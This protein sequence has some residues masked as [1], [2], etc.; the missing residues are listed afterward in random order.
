MSKKLLLPVYAMT[1][2]A[3]TALAN[4]PYIHEVMEYR[5]A[6]GQFINVLPA[7][8][9]GETPAE[10]ATRV[11]AGKQPGGMICL[12]AFGGYTVFRF[13]HPVANVQGDYDFK[14]SGNAPPTGSSEPGI[15]SVSIDVNQNGLPDD[16]WYE[17]AGSNYALETTLHD[18]SVTYRRPGPDDSG[19]HYI[20]WTDNIG[21]EGW[22]ASNAFH[23]QPYWLA[24]DNDS[25]TL[26]FAGTRLAPNKV[27]KNGDGT[28]FVLEPLPWGYVDNISAAQDPGFNLEWAV[29][30]NGNPVHLAYA[31][32]FKVHTAI[33]QTNGSL[34]ETST[35]ITGA[36]DL[37]P[38]ADINTS[39]PA[40][41]HA[42]VVVIGL[43]HSH[44]TVRSTVATAC[45][46]ISAT[47]AT[48]T[49]SLL[50]HPGDNF[51]DT[52]SMPHGIYILSTPLTTI[53]FV[54]R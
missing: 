18:Y 10:A 33:L 47:G 16:P 41:T 21:G 3:Y 46:I 43:G 52:T 12:G 1:A 5:P 24:W 35:E 38:D 48:V 23:K 19:E 9:D 7:P 31:D 22:L 14:I 11:L 8:A 29:D 54:I 44:I 53:K 51:L 25:E 27:D 6:P 28:Y 45:S 4:N 40:V 17:L 13:D 32:F 37:H 39:L 30:S 2:I 50:L 49:R 15:V 20:R 36:E 34:G 42:P 26:T